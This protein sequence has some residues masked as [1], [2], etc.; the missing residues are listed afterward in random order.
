MNDTCQKCGS[1]EWGVWTS[2]STGKVHRY[3]RACRRKRATAY[4]ERKRKSKG[5]HTQHEWLEKLAEYDQCPRCARK[6][7]VIPR[8]PDRRYKYVWTKDHIVPLIAG[9]SDSVDKPT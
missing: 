1:S 2:S 9:G 7:E 4:S 3:C 5:S 6:W 8:R